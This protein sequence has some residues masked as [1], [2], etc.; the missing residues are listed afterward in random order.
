MA[1]ALKKAYHYMQRNGIKDT[2]YASME[3]LMRN[4]VKY[5]YVRPSEEVLRA[6][7]KKVFRR[8]ILFSVIVPAYE[9]DEKY[10]AEMIDSVL[11]Q[12]YE[13]WE[14]IIADASKSDKVKK[15]TKEYKDIRIKYMHLHKN[16]GI[17]ANTNSALQ[18]AVGDY[19]GLLDHDDLLTSDALYENA[20]KIIEAK[21]AGK[22]YAFVYSD[23]DKCDSTGS[24]YFDPNIKPEFNLDLLLSNNYICHFLVMKAEL[25]KKLQFRPDYDGAQDH[26]IVLRAYG[27]TSEKA[28]DLTISYGHISKVLYHWRCHEGSTASNP[29]SKNYA[30]EAGRR[31]VA[32]YLAHAGVKAEVEHTKHKGFFRVEYKDT[33]QY[34][35]KSKKKEIK[36]EITGS[37]RGEIAYNVFLNR[38]DVGAVGGPVFKGNK[39]TGGI[40]DDSK[41]C[42]FDGL[43]RKFSGYLHRAVLQQTGYALDVRNMALAEA[44]IPC[45]IK[46][47]RIEEYRYLYNQDLINELDEQ[48]KGEKIEE[49]FIDVKDYLAKGR[50]EDYEFLKTS[51]SL[52]REIGFEGFKNYYDPMFY[53]EDER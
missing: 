52:G 51:I 20:V 15:K 44:L 27:L 34:P 21:E 8:P 24:K 40:I 38:Y 47:A 36:D 22:D 42:P 11:A 9:T 12:S 50:F 35:D 46:T 41:T 53:D 10:L 39:I 14:L 26:D 49:P 4:R 32:D 5:N 3:Q 2:V 37:R 29:E 17:S 25:M 13:H 28:S 23:E 33:Y 19:I 31:A 48:F 30:Y 45:L 7:S 43:N 6:Q 18:G 1:A 16:A